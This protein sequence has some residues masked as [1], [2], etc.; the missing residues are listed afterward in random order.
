MT[1]DTAR[2]PA[3]LTLVAAV[4]RDRGIGL[5]NQLLW[6]EPADLQRFKRLTLGSPILMGRK[7]WESLG[8][9]LPGRR[10]V[11]ITRNPAW[12]AEGAEAA[13]SLADA[14]A[15]VADAPQA[16]VIGGGQIYAE[17][18][19]EADALEL[20]EIDADFEADAFFPDWPRDRFTETAA[21]AH[22]SAA[23]VRYRFA[24]YQRKP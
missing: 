21:E 1:R 23:G 19:P 7:T 24:T 13:G 17:A 18:L 16:F 8:R 15:L 2:R 20:T 12:R 5:G 14:L 22:E 11:V 3:R 10:N 6:R 4:A 9:P